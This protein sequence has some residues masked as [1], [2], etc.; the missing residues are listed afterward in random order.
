MKKQSPYKKE[1][2]KNCESLKY[3]AYYNTDIESKINEWISADSFK[4]RKR[5]GEE[6]I[7]LVKEGGF[8][9]E[10]RILGVFLNQ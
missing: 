8:M 10:A 7:L 3:S 4:T 6:I 1:Q 2:T 9:E 5:M